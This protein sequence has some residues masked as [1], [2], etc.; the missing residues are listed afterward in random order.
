M[1]I[2]NPTARSTWNF[3]LWWAMT[4]SNWFRSEHHLKKQSDAQMIVSADAGGYMTAEKKG[5]RQE[6]K[7]SWSRSH[8]VFFWWAITG[9]NWFRSEHH[10]KEQS[11][12][13]MIVSRGCRR[14]YDR[15]EKGK[16][17]EKRPHGADHMR[18]SLWW[19]IT[20]SNWFRS[21]HHLK[22]QGD[23]QMIVSADAGG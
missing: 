7:T 11:D 18:S 15:R 3:S 4:G 10:L 6:K 9:S 16:R 12:A 22:E 2:K 20:G 1:A 17:Q 5:K 19:A 21:E 23:A 8:E 14:L 13:Q